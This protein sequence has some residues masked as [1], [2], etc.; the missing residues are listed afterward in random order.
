MRKKK[1]LKCFFTD[2]KEKLTTKKDQFHLKLTEFV[3]ANP[4][5]KVSVNLKI[6]Q[7]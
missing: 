3:F 4:Y 1:D 5:L 2:I 6:K 7:A